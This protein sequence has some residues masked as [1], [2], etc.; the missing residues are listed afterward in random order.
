MQKVSIWITLGAVL[1]AF[2]GGFTF[3]NYLN[4]TQL[5]SSQPLQS[6]TGPSS[7]GATT[8]NETL[9]DEEIDQKLKEAASDPENFAF[10]KGLGLGLYRYGAVRENNNIIEKAIPVLERAYGLNRDDFDILVGLGNAHFDVGYHTKNNA[11]FSTARTYYAKA[12]AKRP[13]DV[14]VRTD[15]G[16][17]YFL[18]SPPEQASAVTEFEKALA[19]DPKHEKTLGFLIQSLD[20]LG[21]DAS[22]YRE[23]LKGVNP[24]N[25]N[26]PR[27]GEAPEGAK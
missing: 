5:N 7:N 17:T 20:A 19:I 3:A 12:L 11:S 1:A 15:V 25:P 18:M 2:V 10:Q 16:L 26:I 24:Q 9:S 22:K 8:Q 6:Q 4:K 21:K 23:R 14:E 13:S 27:P